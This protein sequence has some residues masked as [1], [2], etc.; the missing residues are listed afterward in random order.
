MITMSETLFDYGS[1]PLLVHEQRI[2]YQLDGL[3][4]ME[5]KNGDGSI[6]TATLI[7][8]LQEF[9][10]NNGL[11]FI[12]LSAGTKCLALYQDLNSFTYKHL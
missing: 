4:V 7:R 1:L 3:I 5:F 9:A 12:S 6:F 11:R 2:A 8:N 10:D